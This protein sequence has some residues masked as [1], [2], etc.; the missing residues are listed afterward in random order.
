MPEAA[1]ADGDLNM[2]PGFRMTELGSLPSDWSV[3]QIQ[4]I[5][6]V[7]IRTRG[8]SLP[9]T[10]NFIPMKLIPDGAITAA[11]YRKVSLRELRSGVFCERGDILVPKITP[12]FENGRL[13]IVPEGDNDPFF[14]TTEVFPLK[15][16]SEVD[17]YFLFYVLTERGLR[18][19][20]ASKMEG[21]TGR[22]R[23][24]KHVLLTRA[25]P[26]PPLEEQRAIA[27]VL[28][29]IQR[30]K[31]ATEKV[32]AATRELKKSLMHHL[33]TYGLVPITQTSGV[34]LKETAIGVIS[35][36]SILTRIGDVCEHPQYG[37]TAEAAKDGDLKLL[38]IT[39]IQDSGVNWNAVPFCNAHGS[40]VA[41]YLLRPGDVVVARIGA[42]TGKSFLVEGCPPTTY[43]SYLIRLRARP[44]KIDPRF[45]KYFTETGMYW[46]QID[47]A[48]GGKLKLGVNIPILQG[49][50][51]PAPAIEEQRRIAA[52]LAVVDAK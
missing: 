36:Q 12:C 7:T 28:R 26:L 43:G 30:A 21:T 2:P 34:S 48:K 32:I 23:V 41:K 14:A 19:E 1:V 40:A 16:G 5:C 44:E 24:P 39:D 46:S 20:L 38:R 47:A 6:T 29:T 33:F 17:R 45:L 37:M 25:V 13:G 50:V 10:V 8:L 11:S 9:G 18:R 31:E 4:E 42:T 15:P 3:K 51:L 49:L 27:R 22:R 52:T 35:E